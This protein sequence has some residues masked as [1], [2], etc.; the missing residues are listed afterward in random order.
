MSDKIF[1]N[2]LVAIS[3]IKVTLTLNKPAHTGVCILDLREKVN[4]RIPLWLH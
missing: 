4:V 3:K 1:S 2:N